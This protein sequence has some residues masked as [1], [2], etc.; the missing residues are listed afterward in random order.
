MPPQATSPVV[1]NRPQARDVYDVEYWGYDA[2]SKFWSWFAGIVVAAVVDYC[3]VVM[4]IRRHPRVDPY[5]SGW[6]AALIIA[7]LAPTA[8][9]VGRIFKKDWNGVV[10]W[11]V[12]VVA[13]VVFQLVVIVWARGAYK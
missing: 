8:W 3:T 13:A 10:I 4:P 6:T 11:T 1:K 12:Y 2:G 9:L 7:M 5:M